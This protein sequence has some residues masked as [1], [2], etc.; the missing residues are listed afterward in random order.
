MNLLDLSLLIALSTTIYVY[1][2]YP[3][4]L[5]GVGLFRSQ[6]KKTANNIDLPKISIVIPTYNEATVIELKLEALLKTKYPKN[7]CEIIVVDSDSTDA[8]CDIVGKYRNK[9]VILLQQEERLGKASAINL[10]LKEARGEIIIISDA[11]SEFDSN[12]VLR[13]VKKFD[14][15]TGAVLPKWVPSGKI[16]LWDKI[17]AGMHHLQHK[18]ESKIDSVFFVFG[19]LFA[20]RKALVSKIDENVAADDLEIAIRI[21]RKNHKI[22]YAP[23][24]ETKEKVPRFRREVKT[25]K[26]RRI[27]GILQVMNN[28]LDVLLNRKYGAYGLIIF[29]THFLQLTLQPF[30][31]FWLLAIFAIKLLSFLI[32]HQLLA[33]ILIFL[34]LFLIFYLTSNKAK[35]IFLIL[36]DSLATQFYMIVAIFDLLRGKR[37]NIWEKISSTRT[38]P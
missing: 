28:N 32:A 13:I 30:L 27:T 10:A 14:D 29:P 20:F 16:R 15:E 6:R 22:K 7:L 31:V 33:V 1:L 8:T 35:E 26:V 25:Q 36:Y 11:N 9:G 18:L 5:F 34:P 17:F 23:N 38:S 4:I 12:A 24:I 37:H 21:R 19:E 3:L 2:L